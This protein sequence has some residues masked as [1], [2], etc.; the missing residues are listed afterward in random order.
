M[1]AAA[2]KARAQALVVAA[3]RLPV[4]GGAARWTPALIARAQDLTTAEATAAIQSLR[5]A[6]KI[7]FTRL[8]L[9]P[10]MM[11]D[12]SSD[13]GSR[14][15]AGDETEGGCQSAEAPVEP[16]SRPAGG[17]TPAATSEPMDAT[18]GE[19]APVSEAAGR[20]HPPQREVGGDAG[21]AT[22]HD[23]GGTVGGSVKPP[24]LQEPAAL[25]QAAAGEEAVATPPVTASS[26]GSVRT[27]ATHGHSLR[28]AQAAAFLDEI[29]SYIARVGMAPS[30][31][32]EYALGAP[33]FVGLLRKRGTARIFSAERARAFMTT[34]PDGA[35][36]EQVAEARR[37]AFDYDAPAV[38]VQ[39]RSALVA[40][41]E[42][43]A[44]LAGQRR[45]KAIMPGGVNQPI[46]PTG[47]ALQAALLE[48]PDDGFAFLGR[49][50]PALLHRVV[51][52]ARA[53]ETGP[54]PMLARIIEQG[55]ARVE[56]A[57]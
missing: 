9:M 6:G 11:I 3:L 10:S 13:E 7:E 28:P 32:G 44:A 42:A 25:I 4:P 16:V 48:T 40:S 45:R 27:D 29:E 12:A 26:P 5:F 39:T 53:A 49:R 50:W 14:A 37:A 18:A 17:L 46:S 20:G 15:K 56:D 24:V 21:Q 30:S 35:T 43:E 55:L 23:T 57:A 31:F 54:G 36:R 22:A 47:F 38:T 2:D 51:L 33:G 1:S 8:A 41:V 52:A 19:T 34:W